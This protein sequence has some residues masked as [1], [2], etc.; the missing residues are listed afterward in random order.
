MLSTNGVFLTSV[1]LFYYTLTGHNSALTSVATSTCLDKTNLFASAASELDKALLFDIRTKDVFTI[2][3]TTAN[4]YVDFVPHTFDIVIASGNF[5]CNYDLR[6][7][8]KP[9]HISS[10]LNIFED[11]SSVKNSQDA[12]FMLL[13]TKSK[14]FIISTSHQDLVGFAFK[15]S[16]FDVITPDIVPGSKFIMSGSNKGQINF[17]NNKGEKVLILQADNNTR[18]QQ[19]LFHEQLMMFATVSNNILKFWIQDMALKQ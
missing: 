5:L 1:Y 15:N 6:Y 16:D 8:S 19:V 7:L 10:N 3:K 11:W 14:H 12:N 13:S 18:Y 2:C 17:W 9:K 4:T